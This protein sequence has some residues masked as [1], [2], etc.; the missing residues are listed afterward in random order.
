YNRTMQRAIEGLDYV[1]WIGTQGFDRVQKNPNVEVVNEVRSSDS[2]YIED[3]YD[4]LV[5]LM[6]DYRIKIAVPKMSGNTVE[7]HWR[8]L[9]QQLLQSDLIIY[10]PN[11][12]IA[13]QRYQEF[14]SEER[15][16]GKECRVRRACVS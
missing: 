3:F 14:R 4:D 10:E 12:E 11:Y 16:V 2:L 1:Y 6:E 8:N 9:N 7:I 13:N 15:R 5:E